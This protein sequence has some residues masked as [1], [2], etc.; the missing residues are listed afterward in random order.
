MVSM[1]GSTSFSG[2]YQVA[3]NVAEQR[4][5]EWKRLEW[6][7]L[8]IRWLYLPAIMIAFF[9]DTISLTTILALIAGIIVT[10]LVVLTLNSKIDNLRDQRRLGL[11]MLL[12]DTVFVWGTIL[13]FIGDYYSSIYAAYVVVIIE[14]AI[15]YGMAGSLIAFAAFAGG[16]TVEWIYRYSF[17]DVGFSAGGFT[18]WIITTLLVSVM[19]GLL[20]EGLKNAR[21]QS[22]MLATERVQLLE[23]RRLSHELHDSVLK[24]LQGIALEAHVLGRKGCAEPALVEERAHYIEDVCQKMS[25]EIREVVFELRTEDANEGIGSKL[26]AVTDRWSRTTGIKTEFTSSE[27]DAKLPANTAYNLRRILGEGL[28]N[29]EKHAGASYVKVILSVDSHQLVMNIADNGAGFKTANDLPGFSGQGKFGLS[30]MKERAELIGGTFK[31]NSD[32][33]GTRITVVVPLKSSE[34]TKE[35]AIAPDIDSHS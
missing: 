12:A 21:K 18:F 27:K 15:R 11:A 9:V 10:N 4:L 20:I 31:V 6:I 35:G 25:Q 30:A 24:S 32:A 33:S 8:V 19:M 26:A 14:A 3:A 17:L 1:D 23:R 16:I 5:R 22:E 28:T 2:S 34:Q 13:L 29:I 7:L